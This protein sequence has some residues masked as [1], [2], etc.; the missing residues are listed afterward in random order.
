M[1]ARHDA[2]ATQVALRNRN[3]GSDD[4]YIVSGSTLM[5]L[6]RQKL[7]SF[8]SAAC[9][10]FAGTGPDAVSTGIPPP[11][12]ELTQELYKVPCHAAWFGYNDIHDIERKSVPDFFNGKAQS[13]T[14]KVIVLGREKHCLFVEDG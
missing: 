7:I 13:K 6:Q 3:T 2:H 14:P 8:C 12:P 9:L 10:G 1:Q 5:E 11:E 4:C